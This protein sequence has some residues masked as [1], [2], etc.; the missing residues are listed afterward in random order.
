MEESK[1]TPEQKPPKQERPPE[2]QAKK[3]HKADKVIY[4][5]PTM[6][7][8]SKDGSIAFGIKYGTVF[9]NGL[10]DDVAKRQSADKDFAALFVPVASAP[11]SMKRLAQP[12]T[13]ISAA[14]HRV[15]KSYLESKRE[16]RG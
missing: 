15:K 11:T 12:E 2:Q 6:L 16:K 4:L 9:S 7:E 14:N 8:R 1:K 3:T 5:G 13:E 10:P